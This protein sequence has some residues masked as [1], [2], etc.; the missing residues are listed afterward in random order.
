MSHFF[1]KWFTYHSVRWDDDPNIINSKIEKKITEQLNF[2][3]NW[4]APHIKGKGNG[5]GKSN[6]TKTWADIAK[7]DID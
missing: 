3:I 5:N 2:P 4:S 7:E 6:G 1:T